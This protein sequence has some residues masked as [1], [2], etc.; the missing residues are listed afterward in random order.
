MANIKKVDRII[1]EKHVGDSMTS[2]LSITLDTSLNWSRREKTSFFNGLFRIKNSSFGDYWYM[3]TRRYPY[4]G[5]GG[6]MKDLR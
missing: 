2:K 1:D 3:D 6:T 5:T 4:S